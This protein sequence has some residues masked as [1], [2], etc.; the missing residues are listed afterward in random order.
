ML[1]RPLAD[2]RYFGTFAAL[3]ATQEPP[4]L[5][6][7]VAQWF[8]G[9]AA[10]AAA[11]QDGVLPPGESHVPNDFYIRNED[12]RWRMLPIDPST[13]V[14]LVT[15]PFGQ[16]DAPRVVTLERFGILY[17]TSD[18]GSLSLFPYWITVRDGVVVA[19]E[20]QYIP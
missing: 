19:I 17:S 11:E 20:E 2:G 4:K 8:T 12:P 5:V 13:K 1:G 16:I 14:S 15:Y 6:I 18:K 9:P 3:D 7:D 10:D